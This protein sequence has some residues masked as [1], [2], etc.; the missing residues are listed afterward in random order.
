MEILGVNLSQK[1]ERLIS[2]FLGMIDKPVEF[3]NIVEI[4]HDWGSC[5]YQSSKYIIYASLKLN[6]DLFECNVGHELLHAVQA[7]KKYPS[8]LCPK[9]CSFG[10]KVF[11]G[12][13]ISLVLDLEVYEILEENGFD[14]TFFF[15]HRYKK[16]KGLINQGFNFFANDP[17]VILFPTRLALINLTSPPSQVNFLFSLFRGENKIIIEKAMYISEIIKKVGYKSPEQAFVCLC[18]I[19]SYFGTW[20][21]NYVKYNDVPIISHEQYLRDY[22]EIRSRFL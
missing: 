18:E 21:V 11:G 17:Y 13:M 6:G 20:E 5:D 9:G 3:K 19:N 1:G 10:F 4:G 2:M 7:S 16:I 8:T 14:S 15:N 12:E 22:E